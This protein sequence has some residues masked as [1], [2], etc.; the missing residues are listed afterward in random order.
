MPTAP[1]SWHT[2]TS[3][4]YQLSR[5][6]ATLA[7]AKAP[8]E[9]NSNNL[10][11]E[12]RNSA[13]LLDWLHIW[14]PIMEKPRRCQ[15]SGWKCILLGKVQVILCHLLGALGPR[16]STSTGAPWA[17]HGLLSWHTQDPEGQENTT[18]LPALTPNSMER[19]QPFHSSLN[20]IKI[21]KFHFLWI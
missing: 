10:A 16:V 7:L 14:S 1:L 9:K 3:P 5:W 2:H 11:Q 13:S 12:S 8:E 21:Y 18:I 4:D 17:P 6:Y 15:D 20:R 19:Y